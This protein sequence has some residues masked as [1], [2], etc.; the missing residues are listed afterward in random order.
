MFC[1]YGSFLENSLSKQNFPSP[2]MVAV[3]IQG[4]GGSLYFFFKLSSTVHGFAQ[5]VQNL[6]CN[7]LGPFV[8]R[9]EGK[10]KLMGNPLKLAR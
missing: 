9:V 10:K 6:A 1:L 3:C 5:T 4:A 2:Q 8:T 7:A